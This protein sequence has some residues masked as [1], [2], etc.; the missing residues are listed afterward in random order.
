METGWVL[1][2]ALPPVPRGF[3][4]WGTEGGRGPTRAGKATPGLEVAHPPF[5]GH[6]ARGA[7]QQ[8]PILRPGALRIPQQ[9]GVGHRVLSGARPS[10]PSGLRPCPSGSLDRLRS[11]ESGLDIGAKDGSAP[12]GSAMKRVAHEIQPYP[13]SSHTRRLGGSHAHFYGSTE[14]PRLETAP[15]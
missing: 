1:L 11:S 3:S 8:S 2:G 4:L 13:S 9:I 5:T 12:P 6:G 15:R 7:P 10:R 14:A